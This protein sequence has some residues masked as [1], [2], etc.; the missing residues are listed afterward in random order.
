[1]AKSKKLHDLITEQE[2]SFT[3][4]VAADGANVEKE[5]K[6]EEIQV[7]NEFRHVSFKDFPGGPE[8]FE[9]AAKFCY[10]V[11]IVLSPSNVA[12]LRCAG[13]VLE[14]TEEYCEDNLV[15]KTEM[16]LTQKVFHSL[17]DSVETL[18]SCEHLMPLAESV[19]IV[20]RCIESV[21]SKVSAMDS[22]LFGWP[23]NDE[24]MVNGAPDSHGTWLEDLTFVSPYLFKLLI[25][26]MKGQNL[27]QEIVENCLLCYAKKHIS[28]I[29]R[30]SR[31]PVPSSKQSKPS[32]IEQKELLETIVTNLPEQNSSRSSTTVK[33]LFGMLRTSNILNT[34]DDIKSTLE[35][36]I[37]YQF[38]HASLDDLLMP[39]Y[40]Y[41][42][43][44]LYDVD[45]VQRILTHFL[46]RVEDTPQALVLV[47]KLIDGYLSEIALDANLKPDKFIEL[48]VAVDTKV[49]RTWLLGFCSY[50]N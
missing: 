32:E 11:K 23:V 38:E 44:T 14:M 33:L 41:L 34:S 48:A 6:N 40:S 13:E 36:K 30:T 50:I 27:N 17:K 1:M 37:G 3:P 25:A 26:A 2:A 29:N 39:S 47:G 12:P 9:M 49:G 20:E 8:T 28:G 18:K 43:E 15:S 46:N 7:E 10:A 22:S 24:I 35:K 19:G 21:T 45:C 42:S 4:S 5:E 16:F 31:K